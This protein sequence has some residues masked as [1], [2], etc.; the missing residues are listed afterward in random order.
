[1]EVYP[2]FWREAHDVGGA[3][4]P[5]AP[6]LPDKEIAEDSMARSLTASMKSFRLRAPLFTSCAVTLGA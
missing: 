3:G 5:G 6:F 2:A 4:I 1:M